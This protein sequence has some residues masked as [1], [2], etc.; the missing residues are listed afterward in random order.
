[1]KATTR[2]IKSIYGE[3][4]YTLALVKVRLLYFLVAPH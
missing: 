4:C 2:D 3:S 1:L